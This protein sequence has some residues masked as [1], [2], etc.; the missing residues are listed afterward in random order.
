MNR[1]TIGCGVRPTNR[2]APASSSQAA[3]LHALTEGDTTL[4]KATS[5]TR[6]GIMSLK[7]L[8]EL[9]KEA[10]GGKLGALRDLMRFLRKEKVGV[11]ASG[12]LWA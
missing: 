1:K 12:V 3:S 10:S 2:D 6:V 5:I 9:C 11:F 4:L 8:P 7:K